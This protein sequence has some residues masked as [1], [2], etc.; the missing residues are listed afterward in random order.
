VK[1]FVLTIF[2]GD[3][4]DNGS[5]ARSRVSFHTDLLGKPQTS[6]S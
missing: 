3:V 4:A 2:T 6:E 1:N 5:I